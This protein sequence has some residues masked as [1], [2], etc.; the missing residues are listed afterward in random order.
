MTIKHLPAEFLQEMCF[1]RAVYVNLA[2]LKINFDRRY[3]LCIQK[4]YHKPHFTVGRCWNKSLHLQPLQRCYCENSGSFASACV[5]LLHCSITYKAVASHSSCGTS[6]KL[7]VWTCLV[8]NTSSR[9]Y[10][11]IFSV[12][13]LNLICMKQFEIFV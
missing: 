13:F 6:E 1:R 12:L 11:T 7:A 2:Q 10:R 4:L 5:M 3:A 8:L 9:I